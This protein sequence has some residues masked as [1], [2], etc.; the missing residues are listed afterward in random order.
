MLKSA[1]KAMFKKGS[2]LVSKKNLGAASNILN[3]GQGY[4]TTAT[5]NLNKIRDS[6]LGQQ[7]LKTKQ[8][9]QLN[10]LIN[11]GLKIGQDVSNVADKAKAG[12]DT[13]QKSK[14]VKEAVTNLT[15]QFV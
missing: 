15:E 7:L 11:K 4:F 3:K 10:T 8:G 2:Q 12:I 14:N 6:Q 5:E 1:Q 13:L 9:D